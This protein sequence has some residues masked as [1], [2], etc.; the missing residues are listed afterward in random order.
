MDASDGLDE[1][2]SGRPTSLDQIRRFL[3][4]END[5]SLMAVKR[6]Q[7]ESDR[8]R[9]NS[10]VAKIHCYFSPVSCGVTGWRSYIKREF[11]R[12]VNNNNNNNNSPNNYTQILYFYVHAKDLYL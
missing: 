8:R 12:P 1:S 10:V 11:T 9:K 3:E 7:K 4:N 6:D 5:S 2:N